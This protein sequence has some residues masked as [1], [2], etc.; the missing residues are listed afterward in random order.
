M[1]ALQEFRHSVASHPPLWLVAEDHCVGAESRELGHRSH[2]EIV[3]ELAPPTAVERAGD[4]VATHKIER[5]HPAADSDPGAFTEALE[6]VVV[7]DGVLVMLVDM[8]WEVHAKARQSRA[9]KSAVVI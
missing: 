7:A 9:C 4:Q 6:E 2:D 8:A 1:V 3:L 5:R